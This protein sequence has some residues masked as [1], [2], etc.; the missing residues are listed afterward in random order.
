MPIRGAGQHSFVLGP[1]ILCKQGAQ[2]ARQH[3][4]RTRQVQ[5]LEL[6]HKGHGKLVEF[7]SFQQESGLVL[8]EFL[9]LLDPS[10][11]ITVL[12]TGSLAQH[13]ADQA[14]MPRWVNP[15]G[16]GVAARSLVVKDE[17]SL[18]S[19]KKTVGRNSSTWA[20]VAAGV[21]ILATFHH[22]RL[23]PRV[24]HAGQVGIHRDELE[25]A[26]YP[27]DI[28]DVITTILSQPAAHGQKL[29]RDSG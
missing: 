27:W 19:K 29:Q 2:V 25:K 20:V 21:A 28:A 1:G 8:S 7:S 11:D 22:V 13:T 6:V 17:T 5:P 26:P 16:E 15:G 12:R 3:I 24:L 9:P 18:G 10:Q 14:I 23:L 4:N